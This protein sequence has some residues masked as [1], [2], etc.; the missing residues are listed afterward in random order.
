MAV[1]TEPDF[2][3]AGEKPGLQIWRVYQLETFALP[4]KEYGQLRSGGSYICLKTTENQ[5]SYEYEWDLFFWLG[6]ESTADVQTVAAYKTMELDDKLCGELVQHREVQGHESEKFMACFPSVKRPVAASSSP[7][8][9][10][11]GGTVKLMQLSDEAGSVEVEEV[12]SGG[13]L[14]R[15]MLKSEDVFILDTPSEVRG[16]ARFLRVARFTWPAC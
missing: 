3:G 16:A 8:P 15:E 1:R 12:G 11:V 5:S 10:V 2:P 14:V 9:K 7:P 6:E 4:N 13:N